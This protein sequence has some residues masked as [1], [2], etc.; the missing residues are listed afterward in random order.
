M[1]SAVKMVLGLLVALAGLYWY[2]AEPL[3]MK[4]LSSIFGIVPLNALKIVF[5]GVFGLF[6]IL[7]GLLVA[8]IEYEDIKW[9]REE[10]K[11]EK[12]AK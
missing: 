10:K 7:F 4:G 6:L 9:E 11:K 5:F 12:K 3:Q 8:W 2:A 1:N